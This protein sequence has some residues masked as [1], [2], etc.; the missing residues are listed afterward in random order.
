MPLPVSA[1]PLSGIFSD[2]RYVS[3]YRVE[4]LGFHV[5]RSGAATDA[6]GDVIATFQSLDESPGTLFTRVATKT[7]T[8]VYEV[9]L[10]SA[11]TSYPGIFTLLWNY[12]LDG[13][14]QNYVGYVEVGQPSPTYDSLDIGFQGIIESTYIRFADLF[15]SPEGG[16]HL[17]V[18]FQSHFGRERMAQLLRIALGRLNTISQ[19]R[20]T[21]T[22]DPDAQPFPYAQWG[23]LLEQA[24]YIECVKHLIRSYT[25]QPDTMGVVVARLDRRDYMSRWQSVLSM[26]QKDFD[27][28]LEVFKIAHMGLG[29]SRVLVSGGIYGSYGPTRIP[30]NPAQ[31]RWWA[32]FY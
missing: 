19:P 7:D 25:E 16:P 3:M 26:E 1:V 32:R 22:L 23:P 12:W 8:G 31:P 6:D 28:Q 14:E 9:T 30:G 5:L 15:D 13:I 27:S 2:R 4:A 24:L 29:R 18:Y 20:T 21:Y 11:E 10:S 17:A